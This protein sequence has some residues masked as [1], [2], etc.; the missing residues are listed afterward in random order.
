[1]TEEIRRRL[2]EE[3]DRERRLV[4]AMEEFSECAG[5]TGKK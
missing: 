5:E 2:R 3:Q 4:R 1:V